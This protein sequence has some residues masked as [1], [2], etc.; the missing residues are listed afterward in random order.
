LKVLLERKSFK[1]D[2]TVYRIAI[3]S[4][5]VKPL[6]ELAGGTHGCLE[7]EAFKI[8]WRT[9]DNLDCATFQFSFFKKDKTVV[10]DFS[11]G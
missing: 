8:I 2:E 9:A 11:L 5:Q 3:R 10:S 1:R 7:E 6:E 4:W